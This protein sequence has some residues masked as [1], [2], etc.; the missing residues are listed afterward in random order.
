MQRFLNI[1][2]EA[3][4]IILIALILAF[5]MVLFGFFA[6]HF[7]AYA[8]AFTAFALAS[9]ALFGVVLT[10]KHEILPYFA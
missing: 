9:G 2:G 5:F 8:L 1:C 6:I 3:V 10:V 7:Q 4:G